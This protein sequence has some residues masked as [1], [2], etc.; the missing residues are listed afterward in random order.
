MLK[1]SAADGLDTGSLAALW[2]QVFEEDPAVTARFMRTLYR[3]DRTLICTEDGRLAAALYMLPVSLETE[4]RSFPAHYIYAAATD[5]VFRRRG[6]MGH[7]L[8]LAAR[9]GEARGEAYSI[10][11][12]AY[13]SLYD[14]YRRFG[15]EDF[16]NIRE[17]ALPELKNEVEYNREKAPAFCCHTQWEKAHR[18]FAFWENAYYGGFSFDTDEGYALVDGD[19]VMDACASSE[20]ALRRLLLKA[21]GIRSLACAR[22]PVCFFKKMGRV[23]PHGM[24]KPLGGHKAPRTDCAYLSF[25]LE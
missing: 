6:I 23:I 12:P 7:L 10:L 24:L 16:F 8:S 18:S 9:Q 5:P 11:L 22:V 20:E 2:E 1:Y 17:I 25:T 19:T 21:D 13:D 15:Y 4:N 3:P 14:Y